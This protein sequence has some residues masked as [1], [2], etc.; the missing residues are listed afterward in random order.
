MARHSGATRAWVRLKH[1]NNA[2]SVEVA[3]NGRGFGGPHGH[4][5]GGTG[6]LGMHERVKLVGGKLQ[7]TSQ[8]G[9]GTQIVAIFESGNS[10]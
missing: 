5:N 1:D 8:S 6:L 2:L 9:K 3:D 7:I 4:N 10:R